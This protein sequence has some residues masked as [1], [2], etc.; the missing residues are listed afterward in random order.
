MNVINAFRIALNALIIHKGRSTLTSLGIII[1]TGAVIS[2]V[3]AAGGAR[4][5]LDE[6]LENVG[7][8]LIIIRAGSRT[9]NGT[10]AD[11][12]PLTNEEAAVLRKNLRASTTGFAEVQATIRSVSTRTRNCITMVVGTSPDMQKVRGWVVQYGRFL[13]EEDL[14]KQGAVCVLGQTVREKLFPDMP[15]PVGQT[16]RIDRL[17]LRVVGVV[18]PKGRSPIGGDQDDQIF[19][20]LNTLQ[21]KIV[22][23]EIL[24]MLLTSVDNVDKLEKTKAD[25]TRILREKRRGKEGLEDFDVSSVQEMA[26]IA[27]VMTRTMQFLIG[28]IA[29]ISL[30]VGG[31]GIMN[32]MLVSVTERTREIGIRMAI[33]ATPADILTQFLI[34]AILLSLLGG[35]IGITLGVLAAIT[36]A[37]A[38]NWPIFVDYSMV[39]LSFGVSGGVGIFFGYY[40]ALKASRL[41]PIEA[42][43]YE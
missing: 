31:I 20:P 5:K 33:G 17:Q 36:L 25:I 39:A 12:K 18:E 34:E 7:K 43:R 38:A 32:I 11:I 6:R 8:T 24:S 1:G 15:N 23:D 9:Q 27:V 26:E 2:M 29:S 16:I 10:L 19:L 14:K 30:V 28:I 37:W 21:R 40:P 3:S 41:D 35:F 22:G 13:T 4:T 42:L